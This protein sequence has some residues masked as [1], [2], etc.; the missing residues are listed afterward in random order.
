MGASTLLLYN[1]VIGW[2]TPGC[3]QKEEVLR[4]RDVHGKKRA[5]GNPAIYICKTK[6]VW[7]KF[8]SYDLAREKGRGG[9]ERLANK[10]IG[11]AQLPC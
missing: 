3:C 11:L 4:R 5:E 6:G 8:L 10:H 2:S 1:K 9:I 7:N